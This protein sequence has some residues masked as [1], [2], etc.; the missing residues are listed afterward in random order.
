MNTSQ[1]V[2]CGHMSIYSLYSNT[3]STTDMASDIAV[4]VINILLAILTTVGNASV[5][6]A[7]MKNTNLQ[8]KNNLLIV[9]LA[10]T[11]LI[12]GLWA[13]PSFVWVKITEMDGR[14]DCRIEIINDLTTK[15]CITVSLLI[16]CVIVSAERY[17]A[18]FHPFKHRTWLTKRKLLGTIAVICIGVG[19]FVISI[20]LG[21]HHHI[22]RPV[23]IIII[24]ISLFTPVS[25]YVK[26][27]KKL[28]K[29]KVKTQPGNLERCCSGGITAV[30]QIR[31]AVTLFYVFGALCVTHFPM[32]IGFLYVS[33]SGQ[34]SFY[35]K[36]FWTWG[37][38]FLFLNSFC[39]PIIYSWRNRHMS[40]GIRKLF[41]RRN[42]M[43]TGG[44]TIHVTAIQLRST[45]G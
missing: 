42:T 40:L 34:H 28:R 13:Q 38:T 8:T 35:Q 9:A 36:F 29:M 32:I 31:Y 17:F 19:M 39:N 20:P 41:V 43:V 26:I 27:A 37:V 4:C 6:A 24:L 18:V 12:V 16:L 2:L 23:G 21:I 44:K 33:I 7:Y 30:Q 5:I 25:L 10:M 22:Y 11:D 14:I 15:F 3:S 1:L 45:V